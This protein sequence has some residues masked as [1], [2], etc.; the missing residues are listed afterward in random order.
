MKSYTVTK[1]ADVP[2]DGKHVPIRSGSNIEVDPSFVYTLDDPYVVTCQLAMN[3]LLRLRKVGDSRE[4]ESTAEEIWSCFDRTSSV[5]PFP[6]DYRSPSE[7]TSAYADGIFKNKITHAQAAPVSAK[8]A[9]IIIHGVL[10]ALISMP[11]LSPDQRQ[12]VISYC[13]RC[14]ELVPGV[15]RGIPDARAGR[16]Q[17]G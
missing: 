14:L 13:I 2:I 1:S 12:Q 16:I 10:T 7:Y 9:C 11:E 15:N 4:L 5:A 6:F 8:M 3:P 17:A